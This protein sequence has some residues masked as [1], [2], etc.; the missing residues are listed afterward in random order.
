[1]AAA[2][3]VGAAT[4]RGHSDPR[5]RGDARRA[6]LA[7][8]A[9]WVAA[10]VATAWWRGDTGAVPFD[11][12]P[13]ELATVLPLLLAAVASHR[14]VRE[15]GP[16]SPVAR[17]LV[18]LPAVVAWL[19]TALARGG[20]FVSEVAYGRT[21][22]ADGLLAIGVGIALA[23]TWAALA[24]G[25]SAGVAATP[26]T[27]RRWPLVAAVVTG[28]AAALVVASGLFV[29]VVKELWGAPAVRLAPA[30][31]V[32]LVGAAGGAALA[33]LATAPLARGGGR[34]VVPSLLG[35]GVGGLA[36]WGAG[37]AAPWP[38]ALIALSCGAAVGA[39]RAGDALPARL[40]HTGVVG[41]ALW[42]AGGLL[43]RDETRTL[44]T[45]GR[46]TVRDAFGRD[47]TVTSQGA[48]FFNRVDHQLVA[49]SVE[50]RR[51]SRRVGFVSTEQRQYG[52]TLGE[53]AWPPHVVPA[54]VRGVAQE[55]QVALAGTGGRDAAILVI[56]FR[57][58]AAA[59]WLGGALLGVGLLAAWG[60]PVAARD[61]A[62]WLEGVVRA[63]RG[64]APIGQAD[65]APD[66]EAIDPASRALPA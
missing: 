16:L 35:A 12:D 55:T 42:A 30:F 54:L 27:E 1:V 60:A 56:R 64:A 45:G 58:F 25:G 44:T 33:A 34:A 26:T 61:E 28:G 3:V 9:L 40:A 47:W 65:A 63:A 7:A 11:W 31:F 14:L 51:G 66:Q 38:L 52:N 19:A 17:Q 50:L 39:W 2:R 36:A 15:A 6:L 41:L 10:L 23:G 46:A 13:G 20:R 8:S 53:T 29:P 57:P 5:L 4:A 22:A 37:L 21:L 59:L 24:G 62:E 49:V 18:V 32:P 48:S 43:A